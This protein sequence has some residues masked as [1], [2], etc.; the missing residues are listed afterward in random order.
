MLLVYSRDQWQLSDRVEDNDMYL[1]T[2]AATRPFPASLFGDLESYYHET[3]SG[4]WQWRG[5]LHHRPNNQRPTP[6]HY[7]PYGPPYALQTHTRQI[8]LARSLGID[9]SCLPRRIKISMVCDGYACVNPAHMIPYNAFARTKD[10]H[11]APVTEAQRERHKYEYEDLQVRET[12]EDKQRRIELEN[13][14][15][16]EK[17]FGTPGSKK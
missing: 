6:Y 16:I 14:A 8:M 5:I 17:M 10:G 11:I 7:T 1:G 4:C 15:M 12:R 2:L 9:P 13:A 3:T